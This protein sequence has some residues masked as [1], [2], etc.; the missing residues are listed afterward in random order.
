MEENGS[1]DKKRCKKLIELAKPLL[2]T[3]HRAFDVCSAPLTALE[4]II[5][6]GF[7]RILTSGGKA[8]ASEGIGLIEKLVKTSKQPDYYNAW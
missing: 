8:T 7:E 1:V 6:L 4:D 2:A 3:F 5:E